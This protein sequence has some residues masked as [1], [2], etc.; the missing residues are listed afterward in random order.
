[1]VWLPEQSHLGSSYSAV[2][3]VTKSTIAEDLNLI[4]T[5]AFFQNYSFIL[6]DI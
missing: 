4:P 3:L 2:D 6:H 5:S 1:M